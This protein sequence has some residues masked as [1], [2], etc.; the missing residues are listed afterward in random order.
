[1]KFDSK[2][3]ITGVAASIVAAFVWEKYLKEKV[4]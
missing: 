2:I 4:A 3:F 1:M